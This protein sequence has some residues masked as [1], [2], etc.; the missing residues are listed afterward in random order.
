[1]SSGRTNAASAGENIEFVSSSDLSWT[2]EME[3]VSNYIHTVRFPKP[4]KQLLGLSALYTSQNG[5]LSYPRT[6]DTAR[7]ASAYQVGSAPVTIDGRYV[8]FAI[9]MN[10]GFPPTLRT[11]P[12]PAT[13]QNNR[14][15]IA[16]CT[17]TT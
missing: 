17:I 9:G 4:V 16:L 13:Y 8:S 15:D 2:A 5:T 3:S 6:E 7:L 12:Q 11:I 1:M 14:K 10:W